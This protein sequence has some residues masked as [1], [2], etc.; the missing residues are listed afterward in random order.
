[1]SK[2]LTITVSDNIDNIRQ[3]LYEETGVRMTYVQVFDFLISY[4]MKNQRVQ[5]TWR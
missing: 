3:R 5:T 4:Y 1:M 2:R